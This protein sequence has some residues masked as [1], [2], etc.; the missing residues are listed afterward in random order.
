MSQFPRCSGRG[1]RHVDGLSL[2]FLGRCDVSER[3]VHGDTCQ[4]VF[5][6][7][8]SV[9]V[10]LHVCLVN[11]GVCFFVN[12][13][14][15]GTRVTRREKQAWFDGGTGDALA[16]GGAGALDGVVFGRCFGCGRIV[17]VFGLVE[18]AVDFAATAGIVLAS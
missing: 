3:V 9:R 8:F 15:V 11:V 13:V 2:R 17:G 5:E 7:V 14:G 10:H 12:V 18:F 1:T 4:F 16:G 6:I